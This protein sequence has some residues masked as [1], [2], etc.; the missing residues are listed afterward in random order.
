[1]EG[2]RGDFSAFTHWRPHQVA[3]VDD[4]DEEL[5]NYER[6]RKEEERLRRR[7][8]EEAHKRG[9]AKKTKK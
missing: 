3:R 1:M 6:R 5:A 4:G 9:K 8:Q 7:K 2:M